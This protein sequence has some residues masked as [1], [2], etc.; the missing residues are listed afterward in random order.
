MPNE[1]ISQFYYS[2]RLKLHFWDWGDNGKP[3]LILAHTT[4][5][6][7]ISFIENQVGW[8][9]HVPTDEEYTIA[10]NELDAAEKEWR[11]QNGSR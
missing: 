1:P 8:H 7:G 4:K 9:H 10:T 6:K 11:K 2:H 3:N 5:G